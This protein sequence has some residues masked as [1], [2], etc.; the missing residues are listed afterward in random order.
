MFDRPAPRAL[1]AEEQHA[2]AS[3]FAGTWERRD[4][5]VRTWKTEGDELLVDGKRAGKVSFPH[6]GELVTD[7]PLIAIHYAIAFAGDKLYTDDARVQCP[8]DPAHA[9]LRKVNDTLV[10]RDDRCTAVTQYGAVS[11]ARCTREGD[12][13][14]IA[15][16]DTYGHAMVAKFLAVDGCLVD[17]E[18]IPFVRMKR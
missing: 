18:V 17:Q 14:S 13:L 12:V 4:D 6:A 7:A 9:V 1:D 5:Y 10:V 15:Y 11:E 2:R 3:A 8:G 16:T